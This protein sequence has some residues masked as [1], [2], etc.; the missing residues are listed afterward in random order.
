M[1]SAVFVDKLPVFASFPWIYEKIFSYLDKASLLSC[2]QV[3]WTWRNCIANSWKLM[4]KLEI[5]V[6]FSK[7]GL[8]AGDKTFL[9]ECS[10]NFSAITIKHFLE[11]SSELGDFL[12]LFKWRQIKLTAQM[13]AMPDL[14]REVLKHL[15][16]FEA[17]A[18]KMSYVSNII[19]ASP[20]LRELKLT[21][22]HSE[23]ND[24]CCIAENSLKLNKL[25]IALNHSSSSEQ[26]QINHVFLSQVK[27][28]KDLHVQGIGITPKTLEIISKIE[29]LKTFSFQNSFFQI[30]P[31]ST[32]IL[33]PM[34][35]LETLKIASASN[36]FLLEPLVKNATKLSRVE[37]CTVDEDTLESLSGMVKLKE[38]IADVL[39]F[40]HLPKNLEFPSLEIIRVKQK[41]SRSQQ[42]RIIVFVNEI[43]TNLSI[44]LFEE[45]SRSPHTQEKDIFS[46]LKE[47]LDIDLSSFL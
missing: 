11:E 34:K 12:Q 2:T 35:N 10:R 36:M 17:I 8:S 42:Q 44:C 9:V 46:G 21:V 37:I 45:I 7:K 19:K 30:P 32:T 1:E 41:I 13:I 16:R 5:V 25:S 3:C 28:L 26:R 20:N 38:I 33:A 47:T 15:T 6:D 24:W 31:N 4:K 27:T 29:K 40:S 39:K 18:L 14:N 23:E 22:V 43:L